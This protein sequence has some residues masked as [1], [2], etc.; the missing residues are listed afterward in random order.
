MEMLPTPLCAAGHLSHK[1]RDWPSGTVSPIA[2]A[3]KDADRSKLP[4]SPRAGEMSGRTEG[5]AKE[6]SLS[7]FQGASSWA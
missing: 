7:E 6:R 5:G 1:G 3:A 2:S 4:I